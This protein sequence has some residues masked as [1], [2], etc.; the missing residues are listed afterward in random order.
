LGITPDPENSADALE[1]YTEWAQND[2]YSAI[3][4]AI[5]LGEAGGHI[6]HRVMQVWARQDPIAAAQYFSANRSAFIQTGPQGGT[7]GNL[8]TPAAAARTIAAEW[9]ATDPDAALAWAKTLPPED[10]ALRSA[11]GSIAERSPTAAADALTRLPAEAQA[12][13]ANE[14]A[15]SWAKQNYADA[16]AWIDRLPAGNQEAARLHALQGL[17]ESNP[18]AA[19]Q[20]LTAQTSPGLQHNLATSLARTWA[21]QDP[22]AAA[23]WLRTPASQ[24]I[25]SLAAGPIVE[26]L[27]RKDAQ[28]A[29][30]LVQGMAGSDAYDPSLAAYIR[31]QSQESPDRLLELTN[32][33]R[34]EAT[35]GQTIA[36]IMSRQPANAPQSAR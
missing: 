11:I 18:K 5:S 19:A 3:A 1:L 20:E 26:A 29:W 22:R 8:G 33:I 17:I 7:L 31:T 25:Q 15:K 9:A 35:R 23:E 21:Q 10:H 6:R 24:S 32:G 36:L 28:A 13:C 4:E 12:P 2:P 14:I 34:D 16:K 27:A 30:Q